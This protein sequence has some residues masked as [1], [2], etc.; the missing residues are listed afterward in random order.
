M[1]LRAVDRIAD[2]N[3]LSGVYG[4]LYRLFSVKSRMYNTA[5]ELTAGARSVL[6]HAE[7]IIGSHFQSLFHVVVDNDDTAARVLEEMMKEKTGRVTFMP[8][9]RLKSH[10]VTY[11][12]ANDALPM[13]SK[14]KF[15]RAY[16]MAFEQVRM[17]INWDLVP[18]NSPRCSA[19]QSSVKTSQAPHSTL[20]AMV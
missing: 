15:D 16:V 18:S 8:L 2:R 17:R 13:I 5:I 6:N 20:E 19:E 7:W 4:P 12:K 1:G 14:L 11:P 9:N 3:R 10:N